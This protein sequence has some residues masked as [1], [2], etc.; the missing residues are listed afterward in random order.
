MSSYQDFIVTK[1]ESKAN[2]T[3]V[4]TSLELKANQTYVDTSLELKANQTYV[5]DSLAEI[6]VTKQDQNDINKKII[7][8]EGD[9]VLNTS[10]ARRI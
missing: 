10:L 6:V 2:Q 9:G 8:P 5:N 4:D 7:D 3:D 1:L